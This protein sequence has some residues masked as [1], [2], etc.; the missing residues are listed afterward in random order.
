[1]IPWVH[2]D[3]L[4]EMTWLAATHRDAAHAT[5]LAVDENVALR[6]YFNPIL[7]ALGEPELTSPGRPPHVSRCRPGKIRTAL[8]YQPGHTFGQTLGQLVELAAITSATR[9]RT[10]A[11]P[12]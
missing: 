3:D 12:R 6:D 1:V 2:T 8:G 4:A 5:F 11:A 7:A 10:A 9:D